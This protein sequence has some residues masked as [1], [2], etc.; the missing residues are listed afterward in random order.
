M[1]KREFLVFQKYFSSLYSYPFATTNLSWPIGNKCSIKSLIVSITNMANPIC[2]DV[3]STMMSITLWLSFIPHLV[4]FKRKKTMK[5]CYYFSKEV[6]FLSSKCQSYILVKIVL[7][8]LWEC[9]LSSFFSLVY[10][11]IYAIC[12]CV[13][14]DECDPRGH[15]IYHN[16]DGAVCR[17]T[18]QNKFLQ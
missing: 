17:C 5:K 13:G 18:N 15:A 9:F 11:L 10:T 1:L 14:V 4:D 8:I 12:W 16:N 7:L 3:C 2:R 6:F